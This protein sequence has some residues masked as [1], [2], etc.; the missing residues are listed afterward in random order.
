MQEERS[1]ANSGRHSVQFR[2]PPRQTSTLF[3]GERQCAFLR[4]PGVQECASAVRRPSD[5]SVA[6]R[7]CSDA[8]RGGVSECPTPARVTSWN[9]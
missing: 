9:A 3:R 7:S 2:V 6:T 5:I 1:R 4:G 8:G